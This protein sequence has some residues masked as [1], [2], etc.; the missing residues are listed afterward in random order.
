MV[1]E[2]AIKAANREGH[3]QVVARG[4]IGRWCFM[5]QAYWNSEAGRKLFT[6]RKD[7]HVVFPC[8]LDTTGA[9]E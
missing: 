3:P 5:T 1:L 2:E 7:F 6:D 9:G 4:P 8:S